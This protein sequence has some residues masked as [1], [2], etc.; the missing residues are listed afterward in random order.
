MPNLVGNPITIWLDSTGAPLQG[1]S[2][3]I[4]V[5]NTDPTKNP[6]SVWQDEANTIPLPQPIKTTNGMPV[7]NGQLQKIYLGLGIESFSLAVFDAGG[8][9]LQSLPSC[10]P[11]A[12]VPGL[13]DMDG[14]TF[15]AANGDFTP[16]TTT[17]LTLS[18]TPGSG[19]NLFLDFDAAAQHFPGDFTVNGQTVTFSSPIPVGT[20]EVHARWG[21]TGTT[22]PGDGT[23]TDSSVATGTAL[24][25]RIKQ[26]VYVTDPEYGAVSDWNGTTGTDNTS[27][28]Q[29]ALNSFTLQGGIL[30]IGSGAYLLGSITIPQ[31]VSIVGDLENPE[32]TIESSSQNYYSW[33][34]QL[35]LK[36][37]ATI[38]MNQGCSLRGLLCT[39]QGL[40]LPVTTDAEAG[41]VIGQFGGTAVTVT[42]TG[43]KIEDAMFLGHTWAVQVGSNSTT[44]GRFYMENVH[45][46]CTNGVQIT[47]AEDICRLIGVHCW[48]FLTVDV[49]GLSNA[50]LARGGAAFDIEGPEGSWS[51][52]VSCFGY[53]YNITY[54]VNGGGN[55]GFTG[56]QSDTSGSAYT[57]YGWNI[58]GTSSYIHL[59]GCMQNGAA[60]CLEINSS[61]TW[62]EVRTV[63]CN[64]NAGTICIS[65]DNGRLQSCNDVFHSGPSGIGFGAGT[66]VGSSVINPY[67]INVAT[68]WN[69]ATAAIS[70]TVTIVAPSF[71]NGVSPNPSQILSNLALISQQAATVGN[72]PQLM[73]NMNYGTYT[74]IA[75]QLQQRLVDGVVGSEASDMVYS[76]YRSGAFVDRL[77]FHHD[78]HLYPAADNAYTC[79]GAANRWSIVYAVNGTI[80]TS[81]RNS[82]R[83]IQAVPDFLLDMIDELPTRMFKLEKQ[84]QWSI[85]Y[86]AQDVQEWLE[87]NG[88][89]P[90]EFSF[91]V[92]DRLDDGSC[93]QG[94][95]YDQIAVLE[96]A[97]FKR[98]SARNNRGTH[99]DQ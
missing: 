79:G 51:Q 86:V 57:E 10:D 71:G 87:S 33:G 76:T 63:N 94:L 29:N 53:G 64:W 80:Q 75:G 73:M 93:R 58:T 89:D 1:G 62:P 24:Y 16:G 96:A 72:G 52:L 67:F 85:G 68:P 34:A 27:A 17:S 38:T 2:I 41:T 78:G 32:Q 21:A 39:R 30:H 4:G 48:P 26:I 5:A 49:S 25:S 7:L 98:R 8:N 99:A 6:V 55:I 83:E 54:Q 13:P 61:G 69:F 74:G 18:G 20:E 59:E 3:Y 82:K 23:V 40:S 14:D 12:T 28:F 9:M 46:D 15:V 50:H 45:I 31:N 95:R 19:F 11:L 37:A 22:T 60:C 43:C 66:I 47:G 36:S 65:C 70:Q 56:C 35:C 97:A 92:N 42:G 84:E 81:D 88:H 90:A 44:Q 77:M 91:W